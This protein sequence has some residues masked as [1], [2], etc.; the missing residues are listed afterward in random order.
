M[1]D[2]VWSKWNN[3]NKKAKIGIVIVAVAIIYW[4]AR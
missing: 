3:L 2:K 4:I 1:I